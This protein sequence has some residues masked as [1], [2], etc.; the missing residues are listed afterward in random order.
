[1]KFCVLNLGCKVNSYEAESVAALL[2]QRGF[3][4]AEESDP[5]CGACLVFTCAVT[6][7]A[8]QKSRQKIHRLRRDHPDAIIAVAGCY[9]Q[10]DADSLQDADILVGSANKHLIPQYIESFARDHQRIADLEDL[11]AGSAF[12]N[13][14]MDHFESQTRAYL[15]VQDGCNQFCSYCIIPYARGRER[16]MDPSL[17]VSE[18]VR[19]SQSH[20][21]IV[22][23]GIHTGRYGH[24]YGISLAELMR[25][26]L[27]QA[28]A[29]ERLRI[30][31]IEVTELSDEFLDLLQQE[32][33]IARH[34]HIPLQSGCDAVLKRMNRPYDTQSYY[35]KIERIR[36]MIPDISI[37]TDLIVGFPGETEEEFE[38]T[39][40]FLR[41]CRFSFLHVFP[42]SLRKGTAASSLPC[43][44]AP[45]VRKARAARCLA[46]S[47]ELYDSYKDSWIG[48]TAQILAESEENGFSRGHASQYFEV[49]VQ[50]S[51]PHGEIS[52]VL[53]TRRDGHQLTGARR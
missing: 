34:L 12:E 21:E 25:R 29:L 14:L 23:A 33:R 45:E 16:S 30:S 24:E 35:D 41:R 31:S 15:K 52:D 11:H 17:A 44:V 4:R 13:L 5:G 18:A 36:G 10:V 48:K 49:S 26:I 37:S 27:Q 6:N 42:Y 38:Q 19:L 8:A 2:E 39:L 22:L 50:G 9:A 53:I 28:S 3:Q 47:E 1:M 43:Q 20:R 46:L 32:P 51:I 7:T 40:A